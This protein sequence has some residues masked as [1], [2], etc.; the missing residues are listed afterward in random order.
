[1]TG[2]SAVKSLGAAVD[3]TNRIDTIA[4]VGARRDLG[5]FSRLRDT[6]FA[7]SREKT[8]NTAGSLVDETY[9]RVE[10]IMAEGLQPVRAIGA[11][12]AQVNYSTGLLYRA[13]YETDT[14][15]LDLSRVR[16]L[17]N[18]RQAVSDATAIQ[19]LEGGEEARGALTGLIQFADGEA[20]IFA[21]QA[22]YLSAVAE[23]DAQLSESRVLT[24]QL[25]DQLQAMVDGAKQTADREAERTLQEIDNS[26]TMVI[27]AVV[28][29]ILVAG[30]ICY[31]YVFL[32]VG[33]RLK[34]L[35]GLMSRVSKGDLD[36]EIPTNGRDELGDMAKALAV[37]KDKIAEAE[38]ASRQRQVDRERAKREARGNV[39]SR[40]PN[41]R[42]RSSLSSMKQRMTPSG[43]ARVASNMTNY[44]DD[45]VSQSAAAANAAEQATG[46]VQLAASAAEEMAASIQEIEE[47]TRRSTDLAQSAVDASV[48][49]RDTME[50]LVNATKRIGN[51]IRL[52]H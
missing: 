4:L 49:S 18:F 13:A 8:E 12:R 52:H 16:T 25:S 21:N 47:S 43:S 51:V 34:A 15:D 23:V 6:E 11:L 45:T 46:N 19:T 39:R 24:Q 31:L 42:S 37:F 28:A 38:A 48:H 33:R 30:A 9:Q 44:A 3:E 27:V 17:A 1:M 41:S 26:S 50:D 36:V 20:S 5:V 2:R 29:S 40:E 35:T 14:T 7:N 10:R 32:S 22:S